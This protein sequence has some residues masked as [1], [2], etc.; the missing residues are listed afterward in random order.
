M[1]L[2][3]ASLRY[4]RRHDALDNGYIRTLFRRMQAPSTPSAVASSTSMPMDSIGIGSAAGGG[5][6]RAVTPTAV[7]ASVTSGALLFSTTS[8]VRIP[9][10]VGVKVTCRL[11]VAAGASVWPA[12]QAPGPAADEKSPAGM[13]A[14][15]VANNSALPPALPI[16]TVTGALVVASTWSPKI[17]VPETIASTAAVAASSFRMMPVAVAVPSVAPTGP[18]SV[19]TTV[20]SA[21]TVVSPMMLT[22]MSRVMTPAAN[23]SV[24]VPATV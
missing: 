14:N 9:S 2:S 7:S 8:S 10:A 17:G 15:G 21:S 23:V 11:Q 22:V 18:E 6:S 24:P 19:I 16:L 1:V 3:I 12:T 5:A 4:P 20:S 13:T